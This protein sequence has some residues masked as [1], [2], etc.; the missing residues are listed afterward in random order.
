MNQQ[1]TIRP[2]TPSDARAVERISMGS[3]WTSVHFTQAELPRLLLTRPAVGL[4]GPADT[5]LGFLLATSLVP[6][7]VWLGGFGVP[8]ME[9]AH[10]AVICDALL[11]PWLAMAEAHGA[12]TVYYTGHDPDND[13]LH[14][15]LLAHGFH[16]HEQLRSYDKVGVASAAAGNPA[17]QVRPFALPGD[18]AGVLAI[19]ATAF[20]S[21]WQHDAS[22]FA[23]MAEDYPYFV[24]AELA[25][26]GIAGYQCNTVD[27]EYGFLVRIAVRSDVHGQGI[28]TRLM[29][30]ALRY[31]AQAGVLRIL[32]NA[33]D[34]NPRAHRL[35]ERFGFELIEPR[36]FVLAYDIP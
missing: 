25:D 33:E 6:P 35:Y 23:E 19:E 5:L 32:L 1:R 27:A 12:R 21:P 2:L 8:W 36:G 26:G 15:Y 7:A 17:V 30:E 14:D 13:L 20:V 16:L 4:F 28:G 18:L 24:V 10:V 11:P 29:A 31:F 3:A 34:A 9:R 22:E